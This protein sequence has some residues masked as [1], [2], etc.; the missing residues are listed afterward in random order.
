MRAVRA[1]I[2][3]VLVGEGAKG[4]VEQEKM[5]AEVGRVKVPMEEK[6]RRELVATLMMGFQLV[7]AFF[8][9]SSENCAAYQG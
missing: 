2:S 5:S 4:P 1:P 8:G 3:E 9:I 7:S 6:V